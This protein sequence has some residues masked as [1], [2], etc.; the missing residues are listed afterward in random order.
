MRLAA[1]K[2]V[3]SKESVTIA[4]LFWDPIERFSAATLDS[5]RPTLP[6]SL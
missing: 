4:R 1:S 3:S 2:L 5:Y 6:V